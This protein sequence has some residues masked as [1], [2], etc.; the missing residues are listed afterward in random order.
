MIIFYLSIHTHQRLT[1]QPQQKPKAHTHKVKKTRTKILCPKLC[2]TFLLVQLLRL[3]ATSIG[4]NFI[5]KSW[6]PPVFHLSLVY[7][8]GPPG[9]CCFVLGE[10][11][12]ERCFC[13]CFY[14]VIFNFCLNSCW[15]ENSFFK[16]W[17]AKSG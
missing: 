3:D 15:T 13:H 10:R 16:Y 9:S 11:L 14:F 12:G 17:R 7:P 6:V 8:S 5:Q 4:I 1:K 2:N